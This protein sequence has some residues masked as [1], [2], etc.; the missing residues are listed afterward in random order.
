MRSLGTVSFI[1]L[2]V[3]LSS[4]AVPA[5]TAARAQ[6]PT[7]GVA[8]S[9]TQ[10]QRWFELEAPFSRPLKLRFDT[11]PVPTYE[12]LQLPTFEGVGTL[13]R[14]GPLS[15]SLL[16]RVAPAIELDCRLTCAP[17]LEQYLGAEGRIS[18]GA[19]GPRIPASYVSLGA[20]VV[21]KPWGFASRGMLHLGGL[22]D[23]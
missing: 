2:T 20:G 10:L 12:A 4:R 9:L 1:A 14:N 18:L 11:R 5:Q 21:R 16:E 17:I 23:F 3:T 15:I 19:V 22:L 13:W 8:S 7:V 6:S